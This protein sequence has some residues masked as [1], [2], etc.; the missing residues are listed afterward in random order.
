MS[1]DKSLYNEYFDYYNKAIE[2]YGENTAV[3]MAVGKFY[4]IYEVSNDTCNIGNAS[5]LSTILNVQLTKKDKKKQECSIKNPLMIGVPVQSLAKYT[6]ILINN[7]YTVVV[8]DQ[9]K[10]GT[11]IVRDITN[12]VSAGTYI[13]SENNSNNVMSIYIEKS[14][15]VY[16][17][18]ISCID[19]T[20][21]ESNVEEFIYEYNQ[22]CNEIYRAVHIYRPV[23]VLIIDIECVIEDPRNKFDMNNIHIHKINKLTSDVKEQMVVVYQNEMLQK[24]YKNRGNLS[25]IEYINLEKNPTALTSFV[26]LC[27]FVYN[28]NETIISYIKVP[29]L[30]DNS[31]HLIIESNAVYQLDLMHLYKSQNKSLIEL[32]ANTTTPMGKRVFYKNLLNPIN[33]LSILNN[34]YDNIDSFKDNFNIIRKQ[35]SINKYDLD[36]LYRKLQLSIIHPYEL[37]NMIITI[38]E[39]RH[40]LKYNSLDFN[41]NDGIYLEKFIDFVDNIF[42]L[43][44]MSKYTRDQISSSFYKKGYNKDIDDIVCIIEDINEDINNIASV[45][46]EYIGAP[47]S[48]R[49]EYTDIDGFYLSTTS[50]RG[51]IIKLSN[52]VEIKKYNLTFKSTPSESSMKI[53][54]PDIEK[55]SYKLITF[56]KKLSNICVNELNKICVKISSGEFNEVLLKYFSTVSHVDFYTTCAYNAFKYRYVRPELINSD[57]SFFSTKE[58][59]HPLIEIINK[60][61]IYVPND[62]DI[63]NDING[64]LLYGTNAC[65]KS[66][67]M[68]AIGLTII[69]AQAGMYVPCSELKLA[70]FNYI[71]TRI[72][73]NDNIYKGDSS[74]AVEMKELRTILDRAD[75]NTIV[76]G[77]EVCKGTEHISATSI[78]ASSILHLTNSLDSKFVF[79]TH[80]HE[81]G[82]ID[83]ITSNKKIKFFHLS[84]ENI[85]NHIKYNRLLKPGI[86]DSIYGLEVA[87]AMQLNIDVL[88]NA[89]TIRNTL[90]NKNNLILNTKKSRYNSSVYIDSCEMCG[91]NPDHTHHINHQSTADSNGYI[92]HFHKNIKAN[93]MVLCENCHHKVH[94]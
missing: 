50:K 94:S 33:N 66:S 24:I 52:D 84:I 18:G 23:E 49:V 15:N 92:K 13:D 60:S 71:F 86:G 67:M 73:G 22:V 79:A 58:L 62:V 40:I 35:L 42:N 55:M 80:I 31:D 43:E 12:V 83:Q 1:R 72:D 28:H 44:E 36:K 10:K 69:L 2:K 3:L 7:N 25:G 81:L 29:K 14:D 34:R 56:N 26:F 17:V 30:T 78:I 59:R 32:L 54:S 76:L 48:V 82:K 38:C 6:K 27:N 85:N 57:K 91:K 45:L 37:Y 90:L 70:P 41:D 74:F 5:M 75:K 88:E 77:D 61:S 89:N 51:N 87:R 21:G 53:K 9:D 11:K 65:G 64:I 46:S 8:I 47:K 68:K 4:E 16:S 39:T 93:L 63:S 20:T 19:I